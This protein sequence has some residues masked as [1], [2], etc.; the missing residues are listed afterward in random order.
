MFAETLDGLSE[1]V[2]TIVIV[3]KA[4]LWQLVTMTEIVVWLWDDIV[5]KSRLGIREAEN[6]RRG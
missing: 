2:P 3:P 4:C 1:N 6:W 5:G